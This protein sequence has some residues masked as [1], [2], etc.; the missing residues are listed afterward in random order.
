MKAILFALLML[1]PFFTSAQILNGNFE[2]WDTT[3]VLCE[4]GKISVGKIV[5]Q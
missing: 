3:K 1:P 4:N 5:K 2:K